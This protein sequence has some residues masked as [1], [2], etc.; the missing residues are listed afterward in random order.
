MTF[1]ARLLLFVL[2]TIACAAPVHA[3]NFRVNSGFDVTD[4]TPGNGLCVAYIIINPPYVLPFCTLRAAIQ[5]TNA[6]PG[7]DSIELSSGTYRIGIEGREEDQALTGDYDITDSLLISGAG[8]DKTFIDA[9]TLD[10]V[11][12]VL[13]PGITVTLSGLS[14]IN[15]TLPAGVTLDQKGGAGIRNQGT[16]TIQYSRLTDNT[17][18]GTANGDDGGA[19]L[20]LGNCTVRSSTISQ[21]SAHEGGGIFNGETGS[22]AVSASTISGNTALSGGGVANAGTASLTNMTISSNTADNAGR[23]FGG[24]VSNSGQ[25]QLSQCTVAENSAPDG[26]G[27]ANFSDLTMVNTLL[28]DNRGDNC[29]ADV[30]ISSQGYNLDSDGSCQLSSVDNTDL[31]RIAPQLGPLSNNGGS[32]RTHAIFYGSA[33]RDRGKNLSFI[34]TDQRGRKRPAGLQ[35]DIGA[36]E[37]SPPVTPSTTLL[38]L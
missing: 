14:I 6:L 10:R 28:A 27:I 33:A 8:A 20:N 37:A 1:P 35:Y 32:T 19:I 31:S 25:L 21:N 12:D 30:K 36:F 2:L 26:G 15:G 11:M 22:L 24:G 13:T 5:E 3:K 9:S 38:L 17:L 4:L 7:L 23:L 16:V 18:S 29:L 34:T